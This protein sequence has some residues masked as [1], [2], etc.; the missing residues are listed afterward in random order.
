M[1]ADAEVVGSAF[2]HAGPGSDS[3]SGSSTRSGSGSGTEGSHLA[4]AMTARAK[5]SLVPMV[6]SCGPIGLLG[7][8]LGPDLLYPMTRR[9]RTVDSV[10]L[11][12]AEAVEAAD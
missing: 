12:S 3:G 10:R 9:L 2:E 8:S 6:E 4:A 7:H 11:G 5:I 1:S